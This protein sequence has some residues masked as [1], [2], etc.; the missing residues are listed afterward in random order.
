MCLSSPIR[1]NRSIRSRRSSCV[2]PVGSLL[3]AMSFIGRAV[4]NSRFPERHFERYGALYQAPGL[5]REGVNAIVRSDIKVVLGRDQCLK[6]ANPG[7]RL[8]RTAAGE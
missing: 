7:H 1:S 2:G 3:V 4:T 5:K 8:L 6:P